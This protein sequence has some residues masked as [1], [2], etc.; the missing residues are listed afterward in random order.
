MLWLLSSISFLSRYIEHELCCFIKKGKWPSTTPTHPKY[1][2][3][4]YATDNQKEPPKTQMHICLSKPDPSYRAHM[5][6]SDSQHFLACG[7]MQHFKYE[8]MTN[9]VNILNK[10]TWYLTEP[11]M[12]GLHTCSSCHTGHLT[13]SY[14]ILTPSCTA[15]LV[16]CSSFDPAVV[17]FDWHDNGI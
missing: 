12:W 2:C 16:D 13:T 15:L 4:I 8:P 1:I 9:K 6:D 11:V 17:I 5:M 3:N 7:L 14:K 10:T